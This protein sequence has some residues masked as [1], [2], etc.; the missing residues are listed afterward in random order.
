M[1]SWISDLGLQ[2]LVAESRIAIMPQYSLQ[3]AREHNKP[4]FGRQLSAF[5]SPP[6][7]YALLA[8]LTR[9][10]L[11]ERAKVRILEVGS[12][13]GASVITFGTVIQEIGI[14]DSEIICVDQ[15]EK[16]FV[17]E[18]SSL[19]CKGMNAAIA[20]GQIQKLFHHNVNVCG[21][22]DMVEVKKAS[23]R[24]VLPELESAAFDLVY[25]DGSHKKDDVLYDLQQAKRL[26][27]NGGM[28]CGDDLELIKDQIDPDAHNVALEKNTDFVV[29]P[30]TG[31]SYHPG[32]TEAIAGTFENVWQEYGLW[33]V[34]R[35][36]GQWSAPSFQAS[37]LEIPIHLQHAV[38]IPYGVFNGYEVFQL[39]E[40]FVAYP[41]ANQHW[42]QNRISSSSMEE[43]VLLV[44]AIDRIDETSAPRLMESRGG[45]NIVSYKGKR[46]V[47]AQSV[48][49]VDFRDQGQLRRLAAAGRLLE[50]ET[51]EE[52]RAAVDR[53]RNAGA[54]S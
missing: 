15:W 37:N 22:L 34:E 21:L 3:F 12:W 2:K 27:R 18:D 49:S 25:I 8:D 26:V 54:T 13:A 24:E 36:G 14:S 4:Y 16:N 47:V 20:N 45:F 32:V 40:G 29:D 5:Q 19:H 1:E 31:V 6:V 46:W 10:V 9:S 7:R 48:G 44:D 42:F 39:G 30:R 38:E 35:S 43:L 28:I 52:A 41:M 11:R 23:S 17:P 53:M 50:A 51:M 33:W